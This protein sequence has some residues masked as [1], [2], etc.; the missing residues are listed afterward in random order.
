MKC[1]FERILYLCLLLAFILPVSAQPARERV[2]VRVEPDKNGWEAQCGEETTFIVKVYRDLQPMVHVLIHYTIVPEQG[3]MEQGVKEITSHK[4]IRLHGKMERP[5]ML[6]C[7]ANVTV[8]GKNYRG[9]ATVAYEKEKIRPI[10][11]RP[12][13][14]DGFWK[15]ILE[16]THRI[17]LDARMK[18]LPGSCTSTQDAYEVNFQN[19]RPGSRIYGILFLPR[20]AGKYPAIVHFP[21]AA[22]R[23]H[24]GTNLGDSLITLAI[25]VHGISVTEDPEIYR[26][27]AAGALSGYPIRDMSCREE[28]YYKRIITGCIRAIDFI[29]SLPQFNGERIGV[30]GGSQGGALSLMTAALDRRVSFAAVFHPAFCDLAS[31]EA[32]RFGSFPA[33]TLNRKLTETE[34]K[35]LSYYDVIHF[36]PRIHV[37]VWFSWGFNDET[38]APSAMQAAYNLIKA[39]KHLFVTPDVGHWFYPETLEQRHSWVKQQAHAIPY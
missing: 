39:E 11:V 38:C 34:Q 8:D 32:G 28:Y 15:E 6:R 33:N 36:A 16:K 22:I 30:M 9:M 23:P 10:S 13:D 24:T 20:K 5:G 29:Y 25:G 2:Q 3:K 26:A 21:G 35:A 7:M 31:R 19:D 1:F 4:G 17:P 18:L 27:L 37:P 12:D 14:F